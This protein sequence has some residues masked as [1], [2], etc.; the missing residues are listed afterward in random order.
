[1][2]I[3]DFPRIYVLGQMSWDPSL[4]NNFAVYDTPNARMDRSRIPPGMSLE[5]FKEA[6]PL[7]L[8]GS[9][10][11]Y[12]T[13]RA[14]FETVR[15]SGVSD[16]PG[17]IDTSDPIV[18]RRIA[19]SGKLVD[20]NPSTDNGTQ[21][22]F[23]EL[24]LGDALGRISAKRRK[25]MTARFLNFRRN[26]GGLEIAGGAS[27]VWEVSLPTDGVEVRNFVQ[28][29]ALT[30]IEAALGRPD[31]QGLSFRFHTYRTLYWRNGIDNQSPHEARTG[32]ELRA[33]YAT[34]LNFSN[35]A[36]SI[37]CGVIRPW[38]EHEHEGHPTGRLL[39]PVEG[40]L[41]K[42][43]V[44]LDSDTQR[45]TID[46][47][48]TVPEIDVDLNK[49]DVGPLEL[50]AEHAGTRVDLAVIEAAD[51][52]RDAYQRTAG[53]ID[54]DLSHLSAEQWSAVEQGS[55]QFK[56][57]DNALREQ[58]L[59]VVVE[60]RDTYL[61]EGDAKTLRLKV[62]DRG[63]PAPAGTQ[64]QVTEFDDFARD[65]GKILATLVVDSD[66]QVDFDVPVS[67]PGVRVFV[68]DAFANGTHPPEPRPYQ[69]SEDF[70]AMVR[71]LPNDD[72][73]DAS[74]PDTQ[75]TWSF[76]YDNVLADYDVINPVMSRS[77]D[78]AINLPLH[79][80]AVMEA[81]AARIKR[82][83]DADAF[84]EAGYMPVTRD[85]SRGRRRLL[86]RWCDLVLSGGTQPE[87]VPAS[88]PTFD[89]QSSRVASSADGAS[90]SNGEDG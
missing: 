19:M 9:W 60:D 16:G 14:R 22:F 88:M 77:S 55:L 41:S 54:V 81:S 82:A 27:A 36:Y 35:P 10:N 51:Y 89:T 4:S 43:F 12:G 32:E 90:L 3:P 80:R 65:T 50:F 49:R 67:G 61:D 15:V 68:F 1:M 28:S 21:V 78:P 18:G 7:S 2:T 30:A 34:G 69:P 63:R 70:H 86:V 72:G 37:V 53:L 84:E 79:S 52:G 23:D 74:T 40:L 76:I 73:L 66:G 29:S 5:Q 47:G 39:R 6:L 8:Q 83:V 87:S 64:V 45:L 46:L 17:S 56:G 42:T 11:H 44:A 58:E 59:L 38:L 75:L 33:L 25:R 26:L 20:I 57:A 85:L 24:V 71:T 62:M 31:V 48:E 13:H